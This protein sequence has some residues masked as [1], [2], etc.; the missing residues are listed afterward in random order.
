MRKTLFLLI[1]SLT[2]GGAEKVFLN[3]CK[4]LNKDKYDIT[5]CLLE[6]KGE[7]LSFLDESIK[8]HSMDVQRVRYAILPLIR[9][10]KTT[11]PDILL[12]TLGHLNALMGFIKPLLPKET[13]LIAREANIVSKM[14]YNFVVKFLYSKYYANFDWVIGQS[15]D[16]INDLKKVTSINKD[17]IIKINNPINLENIERNLLDKNAS[18]LKNDKINLVT[19][20]S[21][22]Y[23]KGYD[24]L[25]RTFSKFR[26]IEDY[27]LTILGKGELKEELIQLAKNLKIDTNVSFLGFKINP[28]GYMEQADIF[29]SS[30]RFEGFPNAVLEALAC[31]TPVIANSYPGGIKEIIN[32]SIYGEVINIEDSSQLEKACFNLSK[33]KTSKSNIIRE[34]I[35]ER[36]NIE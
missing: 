11:K 3:L 30:S 27:H 8:V 31:N 25:L 33:N 36:Y 5:L 20:G 34:K 23:Q 2:G 14:R 9:F 29:I 28:Y 26:N 18:L 4:H 10:I 22:T 13:T 16:M 24:L 19:V 17:R 21:L 32:H 6:K 35:V 15:D 1:P 7:Y 12:S